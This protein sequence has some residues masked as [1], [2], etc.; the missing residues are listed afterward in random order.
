[1]VGRFLEN[2]I[3]SVL[4]SHSVP[5]RLPT[6]PTFSDQTDI[7]EQAVLVRLLQFLD[8]SVVRLLGLVVVVE[9][10]RRGLR[11]PRVLNRT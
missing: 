9:K 8:K 7:L 6:A 11:S 1:M 5:D 2:N 3:Y 10:E 4:Y